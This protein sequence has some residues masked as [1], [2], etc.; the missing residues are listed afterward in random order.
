MIKVSMSAQRVLFVISPYADVD[1]YAAG[2]RFSVL[3]P[4]TAPYGILLMDACLKARCVKPVDVDITDLNL[5]LRQTV[6]GGNLE[7]IPARFDVLLAER[8]HDF[9]PTIIG[10]SALF[11]ISFRYRACPTNPFLCFD[12]LSTNGTRQCF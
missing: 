8:V 1:D 12:G 5:P 2:N 7:G 10:V 9:R 4:F 6:E 3:P 11:N